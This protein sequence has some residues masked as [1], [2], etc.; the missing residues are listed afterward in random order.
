[1]A[2]PLLPVLAAAGSLASA[3]GAHSANRA[4]Q[5][6]AREQ[7][8]FQERMSSTAHQREIQDLAKSGINPVL[9][10]KFGGS[11]TPGGSTFNS[12]NEAAGAPEA[13][14]SGMAAKRFQTDI[15]LARSQIELNSANAQAALTNARLN[16]AA[17]SRDVA[18][19]PLHDVLGRGANTAKAFIDRVQTAKSFSSVNPLDSFGHKLGERVY[20]FLHGD[21]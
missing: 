19:Q 3:F 18:M 17:R 10:G 12:Q 20:N 14:N 5:S 6:A 9:S 16:E 11:S 15:A 1:M 8:A 13:V 7:M 21:K 4:N 2:F